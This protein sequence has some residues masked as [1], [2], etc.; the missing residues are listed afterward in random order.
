MFEGSIVAQR[1][2]KNRKL[3]LMYMCF[4][5]RDWCREIIMG[6][7]DDRREVLQHKKDMVDSCCQIAGAEIASWLHKAVTEPGVTYTSLHS[8]GMPCGKNYF[9]KRRRIFFHLLD[10]LRR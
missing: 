6:C 8:R 7:P 9:Y 5:Y 1:L 10:G 4:Q 2:S 3:E